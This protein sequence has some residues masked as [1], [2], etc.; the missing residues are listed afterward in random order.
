L[1]HGKDTS[2]TSGVYV[3]K[4]E[5]ADKFPEEL[6]QELALPKSNEA[7]TQAE[8]KITEVHEVL[9]GEVKGQVGQ[10]WAYPHATG[11]GQQTIV[12]PKATNKNEIFGN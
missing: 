4:K 5:N 9:E 8:I 10:D 2:K 7:N 3:I 1:N 6:Q 11:G 12:D